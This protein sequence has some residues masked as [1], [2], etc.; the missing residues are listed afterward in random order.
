GRWCFC[1]LAVVRRGTATI[2]R[3][4][5]SQATRRV[6]GTCTAACHAAHPEARRASD[7]SD[8]PDC[9]RCRTPCRRK[10]DL[11]AANQASNQELW[12]CGLR[13]V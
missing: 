4:R 5:T 8:S 11:R 7:C 1:T 9:P 2:A 3:T 13:H 6:R 12:L 10:T